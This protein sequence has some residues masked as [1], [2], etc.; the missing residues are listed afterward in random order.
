MPTKSIS[1]GI[2]LKRRIENSGESQIITLPLLQ[3]DFG[4]YSGPI[5]LNKPITLIGK[6]DRTPIFGKGSPAIIVLSSNVKLKDIEVTDS[7]DVL[8][9]IS[10]LVRDGCR[11]I[12]DNVIIN[13][14]TMTMNQEQ[15]I[16]LGDFFPGQQTSTYFEIEV[17][18]LSR[19]KCLGSSEKWLNVYPDSLPASGKY[20]LQFTCDGGKL[21]ADSFAVGGIEISTGSSVKTLW[22]MVH[23]LPALPAKLYTTPIA[24]LLGKDHHI[25]FADG[26]LIGRKRFPGIPAA[27]SIAE[28]QAIILKDVVNGVWTIYQPW[29][30][31]TPTLVNGQTLFQ[32]HRIPLQ[33]GTILRMG[34]LELKVEAYKN[35]GY[36]S[37]DKGFLNLGTIGDTSNDPG[38]RVSYSGKGKDKVKINV[39]VPWLEAKPDNLDFTK[40][41]A[42]EIVVNITPAAAGLPIKKFRERTAILVQAKYE[43]WSLDVNLDIKPESVSPRSSLSLVKMENVTDWSKAKVLLMLYNDGTRDWKP[44]IRADCDWL[45]VEPVNILVPAGKSASLNLS[46]NQKVENL[47]SPSEQKTFVLFDGDGVSIKVHVAVGLQIKKAEPTLDVSLIDFKE[48]NDISQAPQATLILRNKGDKEWRANITSKVLW[49]DILSDS[50][51]I[52]PGGVQK[53]ILVKLNDKLQVGESLI[54]DAVLIDGEGKSLSVGVKVKLTP[55]AP[56]IEIFPRRIDFGEVA[57][58][59]LAQEQM[60]LFRNR[61]NAEWSGTL[62]KSIPWLEISLEPENSIKCSQKSELSISFRIAG[63]IP[64]GRHDIPKAIFIEGPGGPYILPL[65][66]EYLPTPKVRSESADF[67]IINSSKFSPAVIIPVYN[68]GNKDWENVKVSTNVPWATVVPGSLSIPKL[69]RADISVSLNEWVDKLP[70]GNYYK[71]DALILSGEGILLPVEIKFT[72][73]VVELQALN[74]DNNSTKEIKFVFE[75]IDEAPF[76]QEEIIVHNNG[77]RNWSGNIKSLV[78]WLKVK[79]EAATID[80]GEYLNIVIQTTDDIKTLNAGERIFEKLILFENSSLVLDVRV[81]VIRLLYKSVFLD[82]DPSPLDFGRIGDGDMDQRA[83]DVAIYSDLDWQAKIQSQDNWLTPAGLNISGHAGETSFLSVKINEN[84]RKLYKDIHWGELVFTIEN[85]RKFILFVRIEIV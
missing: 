63:E 76:L 45:I 15:L 18:G 46:L 59:N 35:N 69:S 61:G 34:S 5:I 8:S 57:D 85:G 28:R 62:H 21:G 56:D 4:E 6:G 79:P 16:D 36:F 51:I 60:V 33:D 70:A 9:G 53:T 55:P 27:S 75:D 2:E 48:L 58:L 74:K 83:R 22:V 80:A 44:S 82:F 30:T 38:F 73:P 66:I 20:M 3:N 41:G 52:L 25:R 72:L 23:A 14:K 50:N 1:R 77:L 31:S 24:L 71:T 43:T 54:P 29:Q 39:T 26:F 10:L 49:I 12:L 37:V 65:R 64:E 19:I 7:F 17:S 68:D 32:G 67:G 42:K 40:E 11:P 13:G 47:P 84:V 81:N 78:P